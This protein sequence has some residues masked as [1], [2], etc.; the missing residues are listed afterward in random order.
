VTLAIYL[1][2]ITVLWILAWGSVSVANVVSGL[3]VAAFLL[4]LTPDKLTRGK[5]IWFRPVGAVKF[6]AWTVSDV[7]KS[8]IV[9]IRTIVSRRSRLH[10]GVMAIA[11]PDCSDELLTTISNVVAITPGTSPLYVTRSPTV[12]YVHVLDMRDPAA[13]RRDLLHLADLAYAAFGP[14]WVRPSD[15]QPHGEGSGP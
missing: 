11:L 5:S 3:V 13:T 10:S 15:L 1:I 4:V 14:E 6:I 2:A 9:L 7:I 8:N 12:L